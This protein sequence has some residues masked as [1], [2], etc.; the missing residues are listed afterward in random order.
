MELIVDT[1]AEARKELHYVERDRHIKVLF[2]CESGS[3]AWG[4]ASKN[5]DYDVRFFY[6]RPLASYLGLSARRDVLDRE[7]IKKHSTADMDLSGWDIIKTLMLA[8]KSNPQVIEWLTSPVRYYEYAPFADELRSIMQEF[9][10]RHVMHHYAS[11]SNTQYKNYI[12]KTGEKVI[13]KKYLYAIRPTFAVLSMQADP[14]VFPPVNFDDLREKVRFHPAVRAIQEEVDDLLRIKTAGNEEDLQG[15]F[16]GIEQFILSMN[17]QTRDMAKQ[18]FNGRDPDLMRLEDL[19][20]RTIRH[21][22]W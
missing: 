3:R 1:Y 16:P 13:Y 9:N 17:E 19:S 18:A 21:F 2:A 8:A 22:Q 11:M 5:S 10:P 7:D 4:F 15:R 12:A 20:T 6:S 14:L